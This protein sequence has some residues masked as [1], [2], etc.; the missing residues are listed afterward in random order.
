MI[1][2]KFFDIFNG[3]TST[4]YGLIDYGGN[5]I[6][7]SHDHRYNKGDDRTNAQKAGDRKRKKQ[8]K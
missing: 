4:S 2:K 7:G 6:D 8:I 1:N 5:K 3:K